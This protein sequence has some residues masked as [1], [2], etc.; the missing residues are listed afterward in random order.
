DGVCHRSTT[1]RRT[2]TAVI[3]EVQEIKTNLEL[4]IGDG[5]LDVLMVCFHQVGTVRTGEVLVNVGDGGVLI[6]VLRSQVDDIVLRVDSEVDVFLWHVRRDVMLPP[7]AGD[8]DADNDS[9]DHQNR[10]DRPHE[11]TA[12]LLIGGLNLLAH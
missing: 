3:Q 12:T 9:R 5:L 4:A 6:D 1:G 7:T 8:D 2:T 10:D 11:T